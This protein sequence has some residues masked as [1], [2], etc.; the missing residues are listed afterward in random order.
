MRVIRRE[1][2]V[3]RVNYLLDRYP[4]VGLLGARQVGKT[5]LAREVL[6]RREE[7]SHFFD[8][9]SPR[10]L[11]R[12][13]EPELAL[14]ALE[15]IVVLDEIQRMPEL[16]PV[17][18]VLADRP[19]RKAR[20][21]ILG[22]ASPDL[23]RQSSESLA[24]RI[25][26]HDLEPLALDEVGV[27]D[28]DRLWIRGG[29]PRSFLA[30]TDGESAEWRRGF[31]QT[32]LERDLPQLGVQIPAVTLRRFW[33]MVAHS[34]GRTWNSSQF[35]SSFGVADT[36]VRRYLDL[37]TSALVVRQCLPWLENVAKRQVKSP[38]IYLADTGL[39]HTLLDLDSK[40]A[41][42]SHPQL[43][44]SWEGFLV[45]QI[46]TRLGAR[47]DQC[48]FWATHAGAEL[49]LVVV[50]GNL[51]LGFEIKRTVSPRVSRS[52]RSAIETLRLD[53]A[54]VV[55]GGNHTFPLAPDVDAVAAERLLL[56]LEPLP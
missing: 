11:G 17:L 46:A 40:D 47:R 28:F 32:L 21:L 3:S 43:G 56:D 55:H 14:E 38:K 33:T 16:F 19:E 50:A 13:R 54:Y 7:R 5:T 9:E 42:E 48:Y 8:L 24:G 4:V 29:F 20:F 27:L 30:D 49:D 15:G 44:A 6:A 51:R 36:T 35:A 12:L 23:V 18:R 34:H 37:L 41:V 52:L 53:R 22:S 45:Q 31:I 25:L 39:L 1:R 26:Y 10:D 2:H